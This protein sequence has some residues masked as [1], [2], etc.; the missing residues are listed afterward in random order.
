MAV[1]NRL[2]I[3]PFLRALHCP[4]D[5]ATFPFIETVQP[6]VRIGDVS[7]SMAPLSPSS[8]FGGRQA[9]V[10]G[11]YGLVAIVAAGPYGSLFRIWDLTYAAYVLPNVDAAT[12]IAAGNAL[13]PQRVGREASGAEGRIL[14]QAAQLYTV[15]RSPRLNCTGVADEGLN[16]GPY[17]PLWTEA[18]NFFCLQ[19]TSVN[20]TFQATIQVTD[21]ILNTP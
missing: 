19:C 14:T 12:V 15:D 1:G 6:T 18:G 4:T 9:A 17:P 8:L 2:E 21:V 20:T 10:A 11:Q 5:A 7:D 13:V 16:K 3:W